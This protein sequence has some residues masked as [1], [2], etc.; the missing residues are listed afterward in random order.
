MF[1]L[2]SVGFLVWSTWYFAVH[3]P[4]LMTTLTKQIMQQSM[5][6]NSGTTTDALSTDKYM[7]MLDDFMK[8]QK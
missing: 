5:G 2:I 6:L 1:W 4:E 8:G 7:K 3:G